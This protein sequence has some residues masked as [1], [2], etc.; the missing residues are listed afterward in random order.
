MQSAIQTQLFE[1]YYAIVLRQTT[2]K[3]HCTK[4]GVQESGTK[5]E[6]GSEDAEKNVWMYL[7]KIIM[8]YMTA[9]IIVVGFML[10]A[11]VSIVL[12]YLFDS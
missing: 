7:T 8:N 6:E 4:S 9:G 3:V 2:G 11:A 1:W 10:C 5:E 12:L